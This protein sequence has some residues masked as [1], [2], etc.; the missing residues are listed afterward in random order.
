MINP[1]EYRKKAQLAIGGVD[2]NVQP[3]INNNNGNT[4]QQQA[5][6]EEQ[7]WFVR[8][9]STLGNVVKN[10]VQGCVKSIEGIVDAG[11]MLVGLFGADVDNFVNY[12]FTADLFGTDE[13]GEGLLEWSWGRALEKASYLDDDNFI[14]QVANGVG[15]MLPTVA[16][17]VASGGASLGAQGALKGASLG[18][19]IAG[20]ASKVAFIA[21]AAGN[22]SEE[23]FKQGANYGQALGYGALSGAIETGMEYIGGRVMGE[24]TDLSKTLLGKLAIK[25]GTDKAISTGVGKAA[26][27]FVSEGMEEVLSDLLNPVA[28]RI[29]GVDEE[30]TVDWGE[31]PKTF[32]V[33]GATASVLNGIQNGASALKNSERGGKHYV[34]VA[35]EMQTIENTIGAQATLQ[36]KQGISQENYDAIGTRANERTLRSL[37]NMSSEFK[38]MT[39]EERSNALKTIAESSPTIASVFEASGDIKTSIRESIQESISNKVVGNASAD[40]VLR[41]D[42]VKATLEEVNKENG[43]NLEVDN[44]ALTEVERGNY[45]KEIKAI[46]NIGNLSDSKLSLVIVKNNNN[47]NSFLEKR[48]NVIYASRETLSNGTWA[49][50]L[51]HE[52]THFAED[53]KEFKRF[54]DFV[55]E[56]QKAV[57]EAINDIIKASYG[58]TEN[59]LT[60]TISKLASD[61]KLTKKENLAYS[62]LIAHISEKLFT[63]EKSIDRLARS[64]KGLFNKIKNRI[65]DMVE[66]LK[67]TNAKETVSKLR[68]AE[69]LFNNALKSIAKEKEEFVRNLRKTTNEYKRDKKIYNMLEEDERASWLEEH[70]YVA[71]D[72]NDEILDNG[73]QQEE[74]DFSPQMAYSYKARNPLSVT[75]KEFNHLAKNTNYWKAKATYQG[76]IWRTVADLRGYTEK[77]KIE[78]LGSATVLKDPYFKKM[79]EDMGKIT[80]GGRIDPAKARACMEGLKQFFNKDNKLLQDYFEATYG[81]TLTVGD[82]S[83]ATAEIEG[84]SNSM[85]NHLLDQFAELEL[86]K[87]EDGTYRTNYLTTEEL[88]AT[89]TILKMC[90]HFLLHYDAIYEDGKRIEQ[91]Q[92]ATK[93]Y[94]LAEKS[95]NTHT[96]HKSNLIGWVSDKL[97]DY[98][99]MIMSPK[100]VCEMLDGYYE[101][102]FN[103]HYQQ[104]F[105]RDSLQME[106][107]RMYLLENSDK[108]FKENKDYKKRLFDKNIQVKI[109]DYSLTIAEAVDLYLMSTQDNG[110]LTL[111]E[112]AGFVFDNERG[113]VTQCGT[114]T[115]EQINSMYEQFTAEDKEYIKILKD[116]YKKG[117]VEFKKPTDISR[118]GFSNIIDGEYYTLTR[119]KE[120]IAKSTSDIRSAIKDIQIANN[121]SINKA[122]RTRARNIPLM[123]GDSYQK[124]IRYVNQITLY[125]N[126]SEDLA[127]FDKLFTKNISDTTSPKTVKM[128]MDGKV[129]DK[130][131]RYWGDLLADVQGVGMTQDSVSSSITKVLEAL[132]SN[133]AKAQ[134]G[135]NLKVCMSQFASYPTAFIKLDA[136]VLT[137]ALGH[138]V[139]YDDMDKYSQAAT[140]RNYNK[141]IVKAEGVIDK[142]SSIGNVLTKGIQ[143]SDRKTIGRLWV[144]SQ[145][146]IEKTEGLK[147]G[148]IEN[149]KKAGLLLDEVI[150]ETQP[151]YM[152]IDRSALQRSKNT[153]AK[154]IS[155]FTSVPMK[156]V[157]NLIG[158]IA[159]LKAYK[160]RIRNGESINT[161]ELNQAKKGVARAVGANVAANLMYAMICQLIKHIYNK[162]DEEENNGETIPEQILSQFFDTSISMFPILSDIYEGLAKGY[163]IDVYETS[164]INDLIASVKSV[165][166]L[167]GKVV[168]GEAD[169]QD[170]MNSLKKSLFAG[171][172]IVGIPVRNMYNTIYGFTKRISPSTAYKINSLFVEPKSSDLKTALN[173]GDMEL[174]SVILTSLMGKKG[175]TVSEQQASTLAELYGQGYSLPSAIPNKITINGEEVELTVKQQGEFGQVYSRASSIADKILSDGSLNG[176]SNEV[177]AKTISYI[178]KYYYYEAQAKA[179]NIE[180]DSKLYMFGQLI[181]IQKLAMIISEVPILVEGL[182]NKKVLIQRYLQKQKLSAAQKY[183]L[184]G[185]FGYS[186]KSGQGLVKA[187]INRTNLSKEQKET[188]L[189]KCGY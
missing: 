139:N 24:T 187:L 141:A 129:W 79:L 92:A 86:A 169:T 73:E 154:T 20:T 45:A 94:Q 135:F 146:Q 110:L 29:T 6:N 124:M 91:K 46:Q 64:D 83:Q 137:R 37:E 78:K 89:S 34:R 185:Y 119:W 80:W 11:A 68:K 87:K 151:T 132:R 108:F 157:S 2:Y 58:I 175:F 8:G 165:V 147:F 99:A 52:I 47:V 186:N 17:A 164:A 95:L 5:S 115:Q 48:G 184:M 71:E 9:L 75:E 77:G 72:F 32:L 102:G 4:V 179:L 62:E 12:D 81:E 105:W 182:S 31:L 160:T 97:F 178:Y 96:V 122:R 16:L 65:S 14:N 127:N 43:Y 123:V 125:K 60:R 150:T 138:T 126:F 1:Y 26:Y 131:S 143:W 93:Y 181:D 173:K 144:A 42:E 174:A 30:A 50:K 67:D 120:A 189:E 85:F 18:A 59:E 121:L 84:T 13:E 172:L 109:G 53:S 82:I 35:E 61:K 162:D 134:L 41:G 171:G 117:G 159:K 116:I 167:A 55:L 142:V 114:V 158:S 36:S 145:L 183:I 10:V 49:N 70:G 44:D 7:N 103:S 111:T 112:G 21:G 74:I 38:K 156:Q 133:Y 128:I 118:M 25:T 100:F 168:N 90:K 180:V 166:D 54:V 15:G 33:G 69:Q 130:T 27:T 88:K 161:Q 98:N 149:M 148:S 57:K 177:K 63:D 155:M 107:D 39:A 153:L 51:A 170:I 28:K 104:R 188:L 40:L 76:D 66:N 3:L 152:A 101:D 113:G 22:A 106:Y 163:E 19:K 136:G 23:A 140:T 56:D 176:K